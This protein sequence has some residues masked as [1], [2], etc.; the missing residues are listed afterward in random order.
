MPDSTA[1][2]PAPKRRPVYEFKATDCVRHEG[3]C[4]MRRERGVG[5]AYE[6]VYCANAKTAAELLAVPQTVAELQEPLAAPVPT[7]PE[8]QTSP[9]P[10]HAVEEK[11]PADSV[12]DGGARV[13]PSGWR[14]T[15]GP[16]RDG[17]LRWHALT[18]EYVEE[19]LP[20]L[21]H[22]GAWFY[23]PAG[24]H[25]GGH[26]PT[27]LQAMC[28]A[29]GIT[30]EQTPGRFWVARR[31]GVA[32]TG[33]G[34]DKEHCVRAALERY[35]AQQQA[36]AVRAESDALRE[37]TKDLAASMRVQSGDHD[38]ARCDVCASNGIAQR[39]ARGRLLGAPELSVMER[40]SPAIDPVL[41]AFEA[42][43]IVLP[44]PAPIEPDADAPLDVHAL[45]AFWDARRAAQ[46]KPD[47][48]RC[49]A[50]LRR[51]LQPASA[52]QPPAA[53][54]DARM[55]AT[56]LRVATRVYEDGQ[57]TAEAYGVELLRISNALATLSV[58]VRGR[59]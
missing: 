8:Q 25:P 32:I 46:G 43:G 6:C 17:S 57:T 20:E 52:S 16:R 35:H 33:L 58:Q 41:R 7:Q 4:A 18:G 11:P 30:L 50:E 26:A 34:F 47:A 56:Q 39:D 55:F 5:G 45:P 53:A 24:R 3:R 10:P 31:D 28:A 40:P 51:A 2:P 9:A 48:S 22:K 44:A 1:I 37:A 12:V 36:A 23:Q 13:L 29:L 42:D 15:I 19:S 59:G 21:L 14:E 54:S 27:M 49:A 38:R